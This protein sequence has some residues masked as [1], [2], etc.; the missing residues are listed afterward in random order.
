MLFRSVALQRFLFSKLRQSQ[1]YEFVKVRLITSFSSEIEFLEIIA[2]VTLYN[3]CFA[4]FLTLWYFSILGSC[5]AIH[6]AAVPG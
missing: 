5:P 1:I 2:T 4:R 3:S 6:N